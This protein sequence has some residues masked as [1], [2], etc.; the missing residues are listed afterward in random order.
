MKRYLSFLV[1]VVFIIGFVD[2]GNSNT[3]LL[4]PTDDSWV[5]LYKPNENYGS[6][7]GIATAIQLH[8]AKGIR[9]SQVQHSDIE[10]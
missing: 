2:E 6:D 1:A 7:T 4:S 9:I 8:V 5:Y 3:Y 10:W